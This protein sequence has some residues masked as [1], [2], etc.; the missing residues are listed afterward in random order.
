MALSSI[1]KPATNTYYVVVFSIRYVASALIAKE[2]ALLTIPPLLHHVFVVLE[3]CLSS[4]CLATVVSSGST[5]TTFSHYVKPVILSSHTRLPGGYFSSGSLTKTQYAFIF[6][7]MRCT[8]ISLY[9]YNF[10]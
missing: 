2:T 1:R 6:S 3:T 5:I 9:I 7:H 10:S 8:R 4:R